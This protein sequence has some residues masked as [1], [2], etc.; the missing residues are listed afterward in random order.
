MLVT[1][2]VIM[3]MNIKF[4]IKMFFH[5]ADCIL[6]TSH[7]VTLYIAYVTASISDYTSHRNFIK[8]YK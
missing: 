3:C 8:S 2:N 6:H 7:H 5:K 4:I 1:E